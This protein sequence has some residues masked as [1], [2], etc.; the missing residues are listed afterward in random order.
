MREID[1]TLTEDGKNASCYIAS[2]PGKVSAGMWFT[3]SPKANL[4]RT[5]AKQ[6]FSIEY[7]RNLNHGPP[8]TE[9]VV[10]VYFGGIIDGPGRMPRDPAPWAKKVTGKIYGSRR[11][12]K[13]YKYVFSKPELIGPSQKV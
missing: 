7:S 12:G 13:F 4:T 1:T 9:L 6:E 11:G 2:E 8:S 3:G 5:T 10:D